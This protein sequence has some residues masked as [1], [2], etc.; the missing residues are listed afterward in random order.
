MQ[1]RTYR[2]SHSKPTVLFSTFFCACI[3]VNYSLLSASLCFTL[4]FV[5]NF[6][7]ISKVQTGLGRTGKRLCVDYAGVRP[8]LLV[9]G[10][11]L[12]GG[13]YPVSTVLADSPIM[14]VITP[15]INKFH[16]IKLCSIFYLV[17]RV[18]SQVSKIYVKKTETIGVFKYFKAS[19]KQ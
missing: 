3:T 8:D 2:Y 19:N 12:A 17:S 5:I 11:S 14:D 13:L 16:I 6:V 4:V 1:L 7:V 18:Y 9:L 10:K 15:G